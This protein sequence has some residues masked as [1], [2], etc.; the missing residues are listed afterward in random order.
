VGKKGAVPVRCSPAK[1]FKTVR[2]ERASRIGEERTKM[3]PRKKGGLPELRRKGGK[4]AAKVKSM[5]NL[6]KKHESDPA[7][8]DV[9][10]KTKLTK[11][12][13]YH[14]GWNGGPPINH[15]GRAKTAKEV[16]C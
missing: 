14:T 6:V 2:P 12:R 4:N 13:T 11:H 7:E 1:Q 15:R 8:S 9:G 16:E 5:S 10:G 3:A